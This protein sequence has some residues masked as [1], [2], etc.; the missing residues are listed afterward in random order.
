[1][2]SNISGAFTAAITRFMSHE[3]ASQNSDDI[4]KCYST[5]LLIQVFLGA[6]TSILISTVGVWVCP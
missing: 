1:M 2:F 6:V 5:S 3:Y 4:K